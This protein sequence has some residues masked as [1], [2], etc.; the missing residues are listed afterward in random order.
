VSCTSCADCADSTVMT[1]ISTSFYSPSVDYAYFVEC[2]ESKI[3][4]ML[5]LFSYPKTVFGHCQFNHENTRLRQGFGEA[6]PRKR[7]VRQAG[8][9]PCFD[10]RKFRNTKNCPKL[11]PYLGHLPLEIQAK[12][13]KGPELICQPHTINSPQ[14]RISSCSHN[15]LF[16][17]QN[18][19][20][21]SCFR[22]PR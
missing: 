5:P 14:F 4:F 19:C 21:L 2:A 15:N 7:D 20:L 6:P 18:I 22:L 9:P 12:P 16:L 13:N 11:F 10:R 1:L 8:S 3:Y 17:F